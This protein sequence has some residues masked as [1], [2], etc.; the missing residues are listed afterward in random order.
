MNDLKH[1]RNTRRDLVIDDFHGTKVAD[2][3]RW[4]EADTAPE[5]QQWMNE[6]NSDFDKYIKGFGVREEL[7]SRLKKLWHYARCS[8]P[9]YIEGYYYTWRNDGLQNQSIL[10]RSRNLDEIG[11]LVLDPN[12]LSKDGTIAVT[13]ASF[14]PTGKYYAYGLSTSGSDWQEI[15]V[16]DIE[17]GKNLA[18]LIQ[19]VKFTGITW[20]PDD[21]GFIYTRYPEQKKASV[22]ETSSLNAMVYLHTLGQDQSS[23]MLLHKDDEHPDWGFHVFTDED[24]K[25]LFMKTWYSTLPKNQL[26]YKPI[27]K[28]DSPWITI[29]DNFDE[30][31]ELV[32]VIDDTAYIHTMKDAPFG[33]IMSLPLS[34]SEKP[35]KPENPEK[36]RK[37]EKFVAT[38]LDW[39]CVIPDQGENLEDY[40]LV[41]NHILCTFVSHAVHHIKI[42]TTSGK[43]VREINL[44]S[45]GSVSGISAKQHRDEFFIQFNSYLYPSTVL[46]CSLSNERDNEK[47][48]KENNKE[49]NPSIWFTPKIDFPFDDYE[50]IQEFY[51]SKDGT[52]IPIFI[53][54]RKGVPLDGSHPTI[55]Y[56]YGGFNIS[57]TP[58]FSAQNLAWLEKGGIYVVACIRGGSEYGEAWHQAGMLENKQNVFD[59]FIAAGEYLIKEKYT[60][61][62]KLSIVGRSNGGLLTATCLTQ[63]PDLFG[64]VIV[65][66]PV[67][68]MLRYHLFTAGRL[69]TGEYGN[70]EKP[71]QFPFM[72]KY[73]P[74]HNVKMNIV[75]PPTLIMTADTDDRVVPGQAR[76]FAATLQAANGGDSPI[77]IRIEKAAGHGHGKP[78]SK[79]I[80]ESADMFTFLLSNLI[81]VSI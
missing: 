71:K 80:D 79:L 53:T 13:A 65:W 43:L 64:A 76:K 1:V 75:Y 6:Q 21:N 57:M 29:A 46:R 14:S 17:S 38:A 60:S 37:S 55:L 66:V 54:K 16:L 73:S 10:Y 67:I 11:E 78:V 35:G 51:E 61:A 77:M 72:Y 31:Y 70:A 59:D 19:H 8:T 4:L 30:G 62:K 50:T 7:K 5:V 39:K 26:H 42:Y 47:D 33:K 2:P 81:G 32:G 74:L 48:I 24:K 12:L 27:S 69:W 18:D 25:W 3:Y 36:L 41:N 22:L 58:S 9:N 40:A 15:K 34:F 63:R 56:G 28:L 45:P 44:P 52:K 68:D 23:D 20:L 49:E